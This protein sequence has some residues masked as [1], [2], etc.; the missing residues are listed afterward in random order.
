MSFLVDRGLPASLWRPLP[1]LCPAIEWNCL[2][3]LRKELYRGVIL[4]VL[5][6]VDHHTVVYLDRLGGKFLRKVLVEPVTQVALTVW[7]CNSLVITTSYMHVF[8]ER[9]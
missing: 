8:I 5:R 6:M 4:A 1:A 9:K 7:T 3:P 2:C